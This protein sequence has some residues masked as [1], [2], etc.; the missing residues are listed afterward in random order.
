MK[1]LAFWLSSYFQRMETVTRE[2][3]D[4]DESARWGK[5][6]ETVASGRYQPAAKEIFRALM[7]RAGFDSTWYTQCS[8]W[9]DGED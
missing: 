9:N 6:R 8:D 5:A 7:T 3:G 4:D 1:D 2:A